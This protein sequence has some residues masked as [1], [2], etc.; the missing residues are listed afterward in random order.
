MARPLRPL[1]IAKF[2]VLAAFLCSAL[3]TAL[4]FP[5][6]VDPAQ[7]QTQKSREFYGKAYAEAVSKGAQ[8]AEFAPLSEKEQI[9]VDSARYMA[10]FYHVPDLI[11]TFVQKQKLADKKVLEVGAGSGLLQ[12][13]V[14]DYTGL[15]ISATARRFF[16]KPFVEASATEMPFPD[17]TFDGLWSIWV[18]E[19]IP[20]PELALNEM[21]RVT[22]PGGYMFLY[23]ALDV[24]RFT[25]D[26]LHVREYGDLDWWGKTRKALIPFS[27]SE[28]AL[29]SLGRELRAL[30]GGR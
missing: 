19:H 17:G 7:D 27:E 22:K 9:Y 23:P 6:S 10:D 29:H 24:S 14:A 12:D 30:L 2:A 21:R 1:R 3:A 20:N 16:H 5:Y 25:A 8:P 18:L 11:R 26:G 4:M 28:V 13:Q 15:D